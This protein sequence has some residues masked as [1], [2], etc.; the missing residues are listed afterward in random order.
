MKN[1]LFILLGIFI[2]M[3]VTGI[4]DHARES[5]IAK[6]EVV[7][8]QD[9]SIEVVPTAEPIIDTTAGKCIK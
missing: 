5:S 7:V 3:V 2:G 9:A 4:Y 8:E 1:A 6:T